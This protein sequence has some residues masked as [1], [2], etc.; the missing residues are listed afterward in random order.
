MRR[1][2]ENNLFLNIISH[3]MSA[4]R[5]VQAAQR[6]RAAPP[7]PVQQRGPTTSINSAQMFA[8]Q[9]KPGSGPSMPTGRLAGQHAALAQQQMM[10]QQQQKQQ[11]QQANPLES[12]TKMTVPQAI[13]L[14]TLRLGKLETSMLSGLSGSSGEGSQI[15]ETIIESIMERLHD[16][17]SREPVTNT[18]ASSSTNAASNAELLL[19]KQQIEALKPVLTQL[20]SAS[21]VVAK[22]NKSLK[23]QVEELKAELEETKELVITLQTMTMDNSQKIMTY[24]FTNDEQLFSTEIVSDVEGEEE[25]GVNEPTDNNNSVELTISDI[26]LKDLVEQE[27]NQ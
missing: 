3:N 2:P 27:L 1:N 13:T 16:L 20:K 24:G 6:R 23:Q 4:N 17:E 21:T 7:D 25:A 22:E 18:N 8:N 15:D 10:Q 11:Q 26:S 19:L 5:S 12:V 9:A 14:I